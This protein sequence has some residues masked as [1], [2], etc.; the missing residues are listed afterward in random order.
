M[1]TIERRLMA[2]KAMFLAND[3][4]LLHTSLSE[5]IPINLQKHFKMYSEVGMLTVNTIEMALILK[6]LI[7][8]KSRAKRCCQI[9]SFTDGIHLAVKLRMW[10]GIY[11]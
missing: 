6:G 3:S 2:A 11:W 8:Q 5:T 9:L 1:N 7:Y 10:I 4:E